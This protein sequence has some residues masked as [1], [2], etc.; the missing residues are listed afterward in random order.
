MELYGVMPKPFPLIL[1]VKLKNILGY[2]AEEWLKR[3][4]LLGRS[5]SS[6]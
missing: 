5:Y 3:D 2:S 4:F 1:S 6:R